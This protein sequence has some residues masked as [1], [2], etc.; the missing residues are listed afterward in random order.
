MCHCN[1]HKL[2]S[3]PSQE[4]GAKHNTQH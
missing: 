1:T 2:I 3:A 4:T